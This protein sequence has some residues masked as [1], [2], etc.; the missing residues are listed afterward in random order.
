MKGIELCLTLRLYV[1]SCIDW[2][3]DASKRRPL[4]VST[5]YFLWFVSV[6]PELN[7]TNVYAT[8]AEPKQMAV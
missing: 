8:F 7:L 1:V 6:G 5:Q 2:Q 4:C 3:A